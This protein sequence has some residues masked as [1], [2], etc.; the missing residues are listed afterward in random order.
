MFQDAIN[1]LN[2]A[3]GRYPWVAEL[4]GILPLSA[5]IDFIDI[6]PKLHV[7]ELAGTVPLWSW[8][9]TPSGSRL[10]LAKP[11]E[12]GGK[13]VQQD[14]YLDRF[15]KAAALEALD[16][17][18]GERYFVSNPETLRLI[19]EGS[20][21]VHIENG[22]KNM[23]DDTLDRRV[24]QLEIIHVTRRGPQQPLEP[25]S[26]ASP[27]PLLGTQPKAPRSRWLRGFTESLRTTSPLY[28]ATNV[29]GWIIWV[30][31][32]TASSM[33]R[34]WICFSFLLLLPITGTLVSLLH[35][36]NPRQLLVGKR[37]KYVRL[38]V[39]AEHM[40]AATWRVIYGESTIVNSLT[41]RPLAPAGLQPSSTWTAVYRHLLRLC[42]LGQ[43]ALALAAAAT[44][45][46]DAYVICFWIAFPIFCHTYLIPPSFC[47]KGWS[48]KKVNIRVQRYSTQISTRR[49]LLNVIVA[50]NPD[51]PPLSTDRKTTDT[52]FDRQ[53]MKWLN[54]ILAESNSRTEWETATLEAMRDA[55]GELAA[56]SI[57]WPRL[58]D[59]DSGFPSTSW[60]EKYRLYNDS[61]EEVIYWRRFIPEGI[62]MAAKI[63]KEANLPDRVFG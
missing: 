24:Q 11:D 34:F 30:G 51:T 45:D 22:H 31:T 62:Y 6:P 60:N 35:G 56:E 26:E 52:Q 23:T 3:H 17:R 27:E 42:I 16:G 46:W 7:L 49:A 28:L 41:N 50:L 14:C 19:L 55:L 39:V 18:Y 44:K 13:P 43:W 2:S 53:S 63:K 25:P 10:L 29:G 20:S 33:F 8:A 37:S 48:D 1:S 15:G 9:I 61:D 59:P 36:D 21:V 4:A 38:L 47:A 57:N 12:V 5:L 58:E 54:P 32:L 40:N